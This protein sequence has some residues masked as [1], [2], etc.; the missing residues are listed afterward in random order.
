MS[1]KLKIKRIYEIYRQWL[2][3]NYIRNVTLNSFLYYN[4][5]CPCDFQKVIFIIF[6]FFPWD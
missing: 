6:L 3:M 2:L 4:F 5:S 1:S